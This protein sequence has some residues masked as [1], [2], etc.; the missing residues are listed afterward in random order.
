LIAITPVAHADTSYAFGLNEC[1]E[2]DNGLSGGG[3]SADNSPPSPSLMNG[4]DSHVISVGAGGAHNL[5]VDNGALY[6]VGN[7]NYGQL[8]DG[9]TVPYNGSS[10]DVNTSPIPALVLTSGVTKVDAGLFSSAA[11]ANGAVYTFGLNVTGN[12]G[13]G[14]TASSAV[15]ALTANPALNSGVTALSVGRQNMMAVKNGALYDWGYN[16]FGQIGDGTI[17]TDS[18]GT[19]NPNY[20]N[21][22]ARTPK[23]IPSM[24]SGVTAISSAYYHSLAVKNGAAYAWGLNQYGQLGTNAMTGPGNDGRFSTPAP[25]VGLPTGLP[26]SAVAGGQSHSIALV[27]GTVYVFGDN[28]YGQ[29]GNGTA[30]DS[31]NQTPAVPTGITGFI[32]D[33]QAATNG[34]YALDADGSLWTWGQNNLGQLGIGTDSSGNTNDAYTPQHLLPPTGQVFTSVDAG[35]NSAGVVV[36]TTVAPAKWTTGSSGNWNDSSNWTTAAPNSI[37]AGVYLAG[38]GSTTIT[39]S[40]PITV[41]NL[42][43]NST[44]SYLINGTGSIT[45]K[46]TPGISVSG[47]VIND[48]VGNQTVAPATLEFA[49]NTRLNV[50]YGSTLT[51]GSPTGTVVI[52]SNQSVTETG[53]GA[54]AFN[55]TLSLLSGAG[56]NLTAPTTINALA[57]GSNATASDAPHSFFAVNLLTLGSLTLSSSSILDLS[58]NKAIVHNGDLPAITAALKTGYNRGS[59]NGSGIVS[60]TAAADATHLTALGSLQVTSATNVSGQS[61]VA[62]DVLIKYTYYGD[63]DLNGIIDGSDY[64]R[65]DFGYLAKLTGWNNGDF[66]YDGVVDGSDYTLIDNAFNMQGAVINAEVATQIAASVATNIPTNIPSATGTSAVPEPASL[67][68]LSITAAALLGRR[69]RHQ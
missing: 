26:V 33:V 19:P 60:S 23:L 40:T 5:I 34:C 7:D 13:N 43:F 25:V 37:D 63:A 30:G 10:L 17:D 11:I 1:G 9:R 65:I 20:T 57:L 21:H 35:A 55:S 39:T 38:S 52:D 14:G 41:G 2:A 22:D 27:T 68:L 54:V 46:A 8:G 44:G 51:L 58:N 18:T 16:G 29:L 42:S 3:T 56:L 59:W 24:S 4:L 67:A 47:A 69:R 15:A 49:A 61:L 32:T 53:Y 36:T 66:N 31:V 62:G 50:T 48:W 45:V 12:L 28:N 6:A 64:S